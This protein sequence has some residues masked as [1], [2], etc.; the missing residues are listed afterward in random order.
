[1][2]TV[3]SQ[4]NVLDTTGKYLGNLVDENQIALTPPGDSAY[5][6][7][8]IPATALAPYGGQT[9]IIYL[10]IWTKAGT[11]TGSTTFS[12]YYFV[13]DFNMAGS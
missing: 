3:F 11:S 4:V 9:V 10:G 13:D 7:V 12:G 2:F 6:L 1:L 5:R 8:S